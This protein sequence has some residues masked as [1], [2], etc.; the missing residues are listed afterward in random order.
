MAAELPLRLQIGRSLVDASDQAG[1]DRAILAANAAVRREDLADA[2]NP[3]IIDP[4]KA[5]ALVAALLQAPGDLPMKLAGRALD[6]E[7]F[8]DV[9]QVSFASCLAPQ[10]QLLNRLRQFFVLHGQFL[11]SRTRR[12]LSLLRGLPRQPAQRKQRLFRHRRI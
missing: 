3:L 5:H 6:I 12:G 11:S 8:S 4:A 2:F 1:L 7:K 9:F 10:G